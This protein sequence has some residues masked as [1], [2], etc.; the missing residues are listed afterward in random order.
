MFYYVVAVWTGNADLA[1]LWTKFR[2]DVIT[3]IAQSQTDDIVHTNLSVDNV[4]NGVDFY[5]ASY[6]VPGSNVADVNPP[7]VTATYTFDRTSKVTRKGRKA[8]SGLPLSWIDDGF[9]VA[10]NAA[11]QATADAMAADLVDT[12]P[13]PTDYQLRPVIVGRDATGNVDPTRYQVVAAVS[14]P[15]A[16]TQNSRKD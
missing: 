1:T 10:G 7:F 11:M 2:D 15:V 3:I 8:I 5:E 9:L 4:S 13:T 6:N 12:T 16:S 14:Y